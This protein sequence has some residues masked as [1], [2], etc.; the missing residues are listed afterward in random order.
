MSSSNGLEKSPK[1]RFKGFSE[2]WKTETLG[3]LGAFMKGAPLS[4]ADITDEGTP[5][6]LYGELYT[7]YGE[8]TRSIKR[9]TDK[10]VE[11]Q[12]YSRVGD[13]IMP[14]S[15]ETPE[16]IATAS[17][18]MLPNVI[19]AGDLLI[20]RTQKVD[21][22]L[23]SFVVKNKVN[24]QISSVA[25]GKSVVHVRA[26]ELSKVAITYPSAAEQ[27]KILTMLELLEDKIIKQRELI[28]RLKKY[29]RGVI[30]SILKQKIRF[31]SGVEKY[32]EWSTIRLDELGFF[33]GGLSGKTKDDFEHGDGKFIT[34]LNVFRNTFA[35]EKGVTL[36]DVKPNEKQNVIQYGDILFTQSSETVEE[37]GMSSVWLHQS[38]PYLNSFCMA[39]RPYSLEYINPKYIGYVLR[40]EQVRLQIMKE[41]QGISRINLASSRIRGVTLPM[42]CLEEQNHIVK[43]MDGIEATEAF[44][45]QLLL[46]MQSLKSSL[47]QKLFI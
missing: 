10:I 43:F 2:P 7:T 40:S 41:G 26:E 17:C 5:F 18:I 13:V 25:Q 3:N 23:V 35:L 31:N 38:T 12:F 44:H 14:T 24:K 39:L 8:V 28:E 34:Y 37:V 11:P 27:Q 15:G 4:K 42:P 36:V 9:R 45:S 1:L 16:D 32:P 47:L 20:Y 33:F 22:R 6:I 29:K 19:L 46:Q 21:G 30:T